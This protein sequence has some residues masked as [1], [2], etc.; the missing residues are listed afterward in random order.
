MLEL[1]KPTTDENFNPA[2][3]GM[4]KAEFLA[5]EAIVT[6][7]FSFNGWFTKENVKSALTAWGALLSVE[8][9]EKWTAN[10][11]FAKSPKR[12]GIIMAGNIPLVGFH[13]F[14]AVLIS[15]NTAVIKLSSD[16]KTL[17]PALIQ[18]LLHFN[19]ALSDRIEITTLRMEKMDAMIATG[20]NNSMNYFES[21]F[22]N[23]PHIFRK[24][25]TSV[26]VLNGTE[27]PED[28]EELGKDIFSYFGLG[29]RNVSQ[30]LIPKDFEINRFF[31]GIYPYHDIVNH[32][33][34]ANNYDYNKAIH[35]MNQAK[36]LD[37]GFVL[38]KESNELHSPLAMVF[39][40]RYE[41]LE[42]VSAFLTE[43]AESIQAVVGFGYIPFGQ[44]QA[45]GLADY[46]D[47][48]DTLKWLE[49][50]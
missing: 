19:P 47:N 35:L 4:T 15:G 41:S 22:G 10:Y 34:Y 3:I 24:N 43:K 8:N 6:R 40:H 13:D 42:E 33:K 46:A 28:L 9:L 11:A 20:S 39:V 18:C 21:Y 29:C 14:L 44:A 48:V 45:P 17:L 5:Y 30:L 50:I 49:S 36:I 2:E 1:G 23:I 27:T 12:V 37:N 26:A 31:E 16:D 38:V 7:Q 25:R 32:H